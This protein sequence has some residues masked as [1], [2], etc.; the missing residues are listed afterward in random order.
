MKK[1]PL[2]LAASM[3]LLTTG[4]ITV[5]A[6]SL[7]YKESK[8]LT[9]NASGLDQLEID[10]TAG[11]LVVSGSDIS[12]IEVT[13]DIET[14][15]DDFKLTLEKRGNKAVLV[16]DLNHSGSFNWSGDSPKIDLTV[17][18]PARMDLKIDDGSGSIKIN[19]VAS[20]SELEDGSGS[21]EI[22]DV[23]GDMDIKDG[24]GSLTVRNVQGNVVIDDGSGSITAEKIGGYLKI[25]DG[26][27]SMGITDVGGLVTIDDGS[28][29][30][31]VNRVKG[32][33][34]I[35][36]Q[37]SGGFTMNDVEGPVSIND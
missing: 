16:A 13:A 11:F 5:Y 8:E 29:S 27:G 31:S 25:E 1:N 2:I 24:S 17:K 30:I 3:T 15:D 22:F 19:N 26:S 20:V 28:G 35:I 37:G 23:K 33:L 36:D 12:Q 7:D 34:N 21:I 10:A 32:G 14:F 4:C 18:V 9:L 6:D